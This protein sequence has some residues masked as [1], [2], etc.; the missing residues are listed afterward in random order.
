MFLVLIETSNSIIRTF[1]VLGGRAARLS[2]PFAQGGI[3]P[4][5]VRSEDS[6][7]SKTEYQC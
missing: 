4:A 5:V 1:L 2:P 3:N 6:G 7:L